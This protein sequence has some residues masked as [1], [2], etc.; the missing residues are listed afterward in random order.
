VKGNIGYPALALLLAAALRPLPAQQP[1]IPAADHAAPA[2]PAQGATPVP[3]PAPAPAHENVV[4][5]PKIVCNGD[6][7]TITANNSTLGSILAE[8]HRCSGAQIDAPDAAKAAHIFDNLGPGPAHQVLDSLLSATGFDYVIGAS[9]SNPDKVES[10]LLVARSTETPAADDTRN[11]SPARRAFAQMRESARPKPPEIQA[12]AAAD[13]PPSDTPALPQTDS[14]PNATPA[15]SPQTPALPPDQAATPSATASAPSD[16]TPAPA[17][18]DASKPAPS[19]TEQKILDMQK[20]FQ[21][22]QQMMQPQH[23]Q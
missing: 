6:Q 23:P 16:A 11:L 10:I 9:D 17:A 15:G 13:S 5:P 14:A 1:P 8:V 7:L 20:L 12:Q 18:A 21:Q 3:S 2:A 19:V 4:T 22:R